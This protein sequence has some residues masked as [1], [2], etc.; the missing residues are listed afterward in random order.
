LPFLDCVTHQKSSIGQRGHRQLLINALTG[1]VKC[2]LKRPSA[3]DSLSECCGK[4]P[5]LILSV[6]W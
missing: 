4:N 1:Q 5:T 2:Y 6:T 3:Q